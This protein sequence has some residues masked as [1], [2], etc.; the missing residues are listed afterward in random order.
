M[1]L[2]EMGSEERFLQKMTDT[3]PFTQ[4][5]FKEYNHLNPVYLAFKN[6]V[7]RSRTVM[8]ADLV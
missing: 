7:C 4:D 1:L 3:I 5:N 8:F 6:N 2:V